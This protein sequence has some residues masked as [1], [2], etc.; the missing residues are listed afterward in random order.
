V[1][2][3][4]LLGPLLAPTLLNT[5][6]LTG[7]GA[8]PLLVVEAAL[9]AATATPWADCP[10]MLLGGAT[11]CSE[12]GKLFASDWKIL[13][14]LFCRICGTGSPPVAPATLSPALAETFAVFG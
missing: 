13:W 5:A 6:P 7:A 1:F 12:V 3:G 4:A 9:F 8:L 14:L 11:L 2:V 10:V